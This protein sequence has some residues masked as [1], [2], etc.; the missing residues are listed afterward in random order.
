MLAEQNK[1]Q[2]QIER[3]KKTIA[4]L[5]EGELLCSRNGRYNKWFHKWGNEKIYIPQKEKSLIQQ[6]AYKKYLVFQLK[7]LLHENE[8]IQAY[9]E[10]CDKFPRKAEELL[11]KNSE[12]KEM[13]LSQKN[14]L[15]QEILNWKNSPYE[16]NKKYPE[17]LIHK[18]ISG[19]FVRSKS[20]ALIDMTLT[21]YGIPFRY[22][23]ALEL[24]NRVIYPDFTL[25][26][27]KTGKKFYWE[28][29]GLMD[30]LNY[31]HNTSMKI[32]LYSINGIIPS[33][34]LI[35]TFETKE[36]PLYIEQVEAIVEQ[37]FGE[38]A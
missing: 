12:F 38:N 25:L 37:Y 9:L 17:Q 23:C 14:D 31:C 21:K 22:E 15:E 18:T 36:H 24:G 16:Y 34:D 27:P 8:A 32:Q 30:D 4:T 28:H 10:H 26:H 35:M 20:E 6:L 13:V 3:L 5:P 7:D 19:H 33:I 2:Q 1:L 29:F 11:W